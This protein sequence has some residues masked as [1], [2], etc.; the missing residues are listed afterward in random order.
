MK[1]AYVQRILQAYLQL[2]Q[3]SGRINRLDRK[4]AEQLFDRNIPAETV[5]AAMLLATVRRR[6]N[7]DLGPIRSI[8]YFFPVI[9]EITTSP[10]PEGYLEYLKR[11]Q[12]DMPK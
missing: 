3:T 7:R 2:P 8:H 11:A 4:F 6:R 5:E 1:N 9:Q 12:E 10:L